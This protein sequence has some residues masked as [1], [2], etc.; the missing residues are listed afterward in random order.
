MPIWM[1]EQS[2]LPDLEYGAIRI[3]IRKTALERGELK[4]QFLPEFVR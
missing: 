2:G 3:V 1:I 4:R